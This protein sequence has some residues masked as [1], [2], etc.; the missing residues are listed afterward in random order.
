MPDSLA[1]DIQDIRIQRTDCLRAI[2]DSSNR[3]LE[4]ILVLVEKTFLIEVLERRNEQA[5]NPFP[6]HSIALGCLGTS[7]FE[8]SAAKIAQERKHYGSLAKLRLAESRGIGPAIGYP[9]ATRTM[10]KHNT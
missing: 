9:S 5:P 2:V 6:I 3:R 10:S 7:Y 1:K 4:L 8:Q